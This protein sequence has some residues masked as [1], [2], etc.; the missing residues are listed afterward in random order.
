MTSP[1]QSWLDKP[2]VLIQ[3][4]DLSLHPESATKSWNSITRALVLTLILSIVGAKTLGPS[5]PVL[6]TILFVVYYGQFIAESYFPSYSK[7]EKFTNMPATDVPV[8]CSLPTG[9]AD[10]LPY[11]QGMEYT[12]PTDKN[13][14]MNVLLD[15]LQYNPARQPAAPVN[16]P[17]VKA[18]MDDYFKVQWTSDPTDVFGRNQSQRQFYTMPNTSIPNDRANYQ[19]WLY[20]I[21][22]KTCKEAGGAACVPG[23]NGGAL[24]WLSQ[25]N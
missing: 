17:L 5:W 13:P 21:P 20:L 18:E 11:N 1:E 7:K 2:I 15:E 22:G 8:N 4:F 23:T 14:F 24:P 9:F 6:L 3:S 10:K 16:D 25:P 19:N 12:M